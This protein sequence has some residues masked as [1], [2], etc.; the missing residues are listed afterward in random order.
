MS[1]HPYSQAEATLNNEK[2]L[3]LA[4]IKLRLSEGNQSLSYLLSHLL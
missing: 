1:W 2:S 4:I 3:A